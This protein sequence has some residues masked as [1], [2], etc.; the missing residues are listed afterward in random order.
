[1]IGIDLFSYLLADESLPE[2]L[3]P[4]I[5]IPNAK[6][7]KPP[8]ERK[9]RFADYG[10]RTGPSHGIYLPDV[11]R[12]IVPVLSVLRTGSSLDNRFVLPVSQ[13]QPKGRTG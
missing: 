5:E 8:S 1:M 6:I 12:K 7:W 10:H 9:S 3:T 11:R 2:V 4:P 13:T